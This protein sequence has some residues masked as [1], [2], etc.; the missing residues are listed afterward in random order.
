MP[1][2]MI[3]RFSKRLYQPNVWAGDMLPGTAWQCAGTIWRQ[4]GALYK[5]LDELREIEQQKDAEKEGGGAQEKL[6]SRPRNVS[7]SSPSS[8]RRVLK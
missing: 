6:E 1:V 3:D 5:S 2:P 4:E 7:I 8:S